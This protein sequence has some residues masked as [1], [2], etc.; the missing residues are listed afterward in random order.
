MP[1]LLVRFAFRNPR[2]LRGILGEED[3]PLWEEVTVVQHLKKL[4]MHNSMAPG[5]MHRQMLRNLADV[6]VRVLSIIFKRLWQLW[7]I[8]EGWKRANVTPINK[9]STKEDLG[10][11]RLVSLT[12]VPGKAFDTVSLNIVIHKLIKYQLHKWAVRWVE[13]WLNCKPQSCVH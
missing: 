9:K 8:P 11:Y 4:D 2:S 13:N 3:L 5:R 10:T 6:I 12:L 7:E 1:S